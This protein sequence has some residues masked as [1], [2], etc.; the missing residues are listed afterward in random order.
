[1]A[2]PQ[3]IDD[4]ESDGEENENTDHEAGSKIE[5]LH[6]DEAEA[7]HCENVNPHDYRL[8]SSDDEIHLVDND[9][10]TDMDSMIAVTRRMMIILWHSRT[11]IFLNSISCNTI[12]W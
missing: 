8:L 10:V 5:D 6:I 4:T 11:H 7:M 3:I 1:M 12:I 9:Q 2:A